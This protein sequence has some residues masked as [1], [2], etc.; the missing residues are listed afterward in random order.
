MCEVAIV[1][2]DNR[3]TT[4]IHDSG[5]VEIR[6]GRYARFEEGVTQAPAIQG[7]FTWRICRGYMVS[8]TCRCIIA[9]ADEIPRV[10]REH[11]ATNLESE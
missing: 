2:C 11:L 1:E 10:D 5:F 3:P 6:N 4:P 7:S 8:Y 9:S